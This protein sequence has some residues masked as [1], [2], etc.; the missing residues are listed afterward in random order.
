MNFRDFI[1]ATLSVWLCIAVVTCS[2]NVKAHGTHSGIGIEGDVTEWKQSGINLFVTYKLKND[3]FICVIYG[4]A[5][6]KD[7]PILHLLRSEPG[8]C[9]EIYFNDNS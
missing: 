3:S 4:V 7:A 5:K 8:K 6:H 2:T 1:I 9:S